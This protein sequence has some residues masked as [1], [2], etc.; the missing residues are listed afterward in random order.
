MQ[1]SKPKRG[2]PRGRNRQSRRPKQF[3]RPR[4]EERP[5]NEVR[6]LQVNR[7]CYFYGEQICFNCKRQNHVQSADLM[8]CTMERSEINTRRAYCLFRAR[9][10]RD[11]LFVFC[12]NC[13]DYLRSKSLIKIAGHDWFYIWPI[14]IWKLL[15][16]DEGRYVDEVWSVI[17]MNW[18]G[19]WVRMVEANLMRRPGQISMTHPAAIFRDVTDVYN[20]RKRVMKEL[21]IGD[22]LSKW[23]STIPD[24]LCPW[25]CTEYIEDTGGV[26]FDVLIQRCFP[27][28]VFPL[29]QANVAASRIEACESSRHDF[30]W[31]GSF[32]F[33]GN[34]QWVIQ[35]CVA[36]LPRVGLR[37][38][39]CRNCSGGHHKRFLHTPRLPQIL[40]A[41][42]GNQLA[43]A[44]LQP[45]NVRVIRAG[46]WNVSHQM[47][48]Q[49]SGYSGCDTCYVGNH[50]RF[51]SRSLIGSISE[52]L[53]ITGRQDVR[54]LLDRLCE[55][56]VLDPDT[57][58]LYKMHAEKMF[59]K[60][61]DFDSMRYG[62]TYV[63][64]ADCIHL[65]ACIDDVKTIPIVFENDETGTIRCKWPRRIVFVHEHTVYGAWFPRLP[66]KLLGDQFSAEKTLH[67]DL[68]VFIVVLL[69]S[70]PKLWEFLSGATKRYDDWSGKLLNFV[71]TQVFSRLV[72]QQGRSTRSVHPDPFTDACKWGHLDALT[73]LYDLL[74]WDYLAHESDVVPFLPEL[75]FQLIALLDVFLCERYARNCVIDL[76][77]FT[78]GLDVDQCDASAEYIVVMNLE[79]GT[80]VTVDA[81]DETIIVNGKEFEMRCIFTARSAG[82]GGKPV[83]YVRHGNQ[84][85]SWW[86]HRLGRIY[87][88]RDDQFR[89]S[90]LFSCVVYAGELPLD[91]KQ[92]RLQLL[93]ALG[94]QTNMSCTLHG[95]PM[96]VQQNTDYF[97]A[98]S[99]MTPVACVSSDCGHHALYICPQQ[100]CTA[101]MCSNCMKQHNASGLDKIEVDPLVATS[102]VVSRMVSSDGED[103]DRSSCSMFSAENASDIE[104]EDLHIGQQLVPVLCD[105][106]SV[107]DDSGDRCIYIPGTLVGD[108]DNPLNIQMESKMAEVGVR[109][110]LNHA[111]SMLV[112][113]N[114]ELVPSRREQQF[115][116]K[117][118]VGSPGETVP[119]VTLDPMLFPDVC[120]FDNKFDGS[121]IGG[122]PTAFFGGSEVCRKYN[123]ASIHDHARVRVTFPFSTSSTQ[124]RSMYFF[125][126]GISNEKLSTTDTRIIKDRGIF[127]TSMKGGMKSTRQ[128]DRV[129]TE[130]M[131]CHQQV[132]CLCASQKYHTDNLFL[133]FTANQSMTP[134]LKW[135]MDWLRSNDI[136][137]NY[138]YYDP[139][140]RQEIVLAFADAFAPL[141]NRN[142][143]KVMRDLLQYIV[144][145]EEKPVGEVESFF[146]RKEWQ[147]EEGNIDHWHILLQILFDASNTEQLRKFQSM[148]RGTVI[149]VLTPDEVLDFER[150]GVFKTKSDWMGV[151]GLAGTILTHR[152]GQ[153]KRHQRRIGTGDQDLKD[154]V[155]D[156]FDIRQSQTE[157]VTLPIPVPHTKEAWE[158]LCT[159]RLARPAADD[160]MNDYE[161]TH[162]L[163]VTE[164]HYAPRRLADGYMSP[165]HPLFFSALRSMQNIQHVSGHSKNAYVCGYVANMDEN[166]RVYLNAKSADVRSVAVTTEFLYNE[167]LSS[168]KH[169][170]RQRAEKAGRR[171]HTTGRAITRHQI[172][173]HIL[174]L[175]EV[176][177]NR[178]SIV[179]P[180]TA[181]ESR[182]GVERSA[183][184]AS[185]DNQEAQEYIHWY[186][187]QPGRDL[188]S[189][190]LYPDAERL[191]LN[192]DP[193]RQFSHHQVLTAE[194]DIHSHVTTD[195]ITTFSI[196]PPELSFV[197][198]VQ[199]YFRFFVLSKDKMSPSRYRQGLEQM[200]WMDGAGRR[201]LLRDKAL[202]EIRQYIQAKMTAK[203]P[204]HP[205]MLTLLTKLYDYQQQ[206][207]SY[208]VMTE[209]QTAEWTLLRK[210]YISPCGI[211]LLPIPVVT[212]IKPMDSIQ[213]AYHIVLSLGSYL[214]ELDLLSQRSLRDAY[215]DASLYSAQHPEQSIRTLL[216]RYVT[217]QLGYQPIGTQLFDVYLTAA[218]RTFR[219][220]LI[221][222][223]LPVHSLP[224]CLATQCYAD[225]AD[226]IRQRLDAF[227][228]QVLTVC[229]DRLADMLRELLGYLPTPEDV[230][231]GKIT[232]RLRGSMP[233]GRYQSLRS[234]HEQ[235]ELRVLI[236][237]LVHDYM[238]PNRETQA[239]KLIIVGAP[240]TGKTYCEFYAV[241]YMYA[242]GLFG[243]PTSHQAETASAAGGI[244]DAKA[245]HTPV[246]ANKTQQNPYHDAEKAIMALARDPFATQLQLEMDCEIKEE[247]EML[248]AATWAAEDIIQR[249]ICD[250]KDY[251]A[252]K[253]LV[254][255]MDHRQIKPC[256][257]ESF[258]LSPVVLS[259]CTIFRLRYF[260]RS[261][262]D[263]AL[264]RF[265]EILRIPKH[266]LR[267]QREE[268]LH[269]FR[270]IYYDNAIVVPDWSDERI[271]DTT[272]R[273]VPKRVPVRELERAYINEM[274]SKLDPHQYH[275]VYS[276]D[277]QK[278][279]Y[280][281]GNW[282][283][284]CRS[285]SGFLDHAVKEPRVLTLYE[286]GLYQ[287]T[288]NDTTRERKFNQSRLAVL[289]DLPPENHDFRSFAEI[290]VWMAPAA[291]KTPPSM[292]DR[293]HERL[294]HLGW[295]P[296]KIGRCRAYTQTDH[297]NG[298][299]A[300]RVQYGLRHFIATTIHAVIGATLDKA[301]IKVSRSDPDYSIWD[302]GMLQVAVTR[303][304]T[305]KDLIWVGDK[306]DTLCMLVDILLQE[307]RETEYVDSLIDRLSVNRLD[308][309]EFANTGVGNPYVHAVA[310]RSNLRR[311]QQQRIPN[312]NT[313]FSYIIIS[314]R[315]QAN[316]YIGEAVNLTVR[317]RKHNGG[318]ASKQ[319][320]DFAYRPWALLAYVAGFQGDITAHKTFEKRWQYYARR[321]RR[322]GDRSIHSAVTAAHYAIAEYPT[323]PLRL[324]NYA[325]SATTYE[326]IL[327]TEDVEV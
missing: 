152:G 45:R 163:L 192:L 143:D 300:K 78:G 129:F 98:N 8:F 132:N 249:T 168:S 99:H 161:I 53:S 174:G 323:F 205:T 169:F 222:E 287:I 223:S 120:P 243:V 74:G 187:L 239:G 154:R 22:L 211:A 284:A 177:T 4:R 193:W 212:S 147:G 18:R 111:G 232:D 127:A 272:I 92:L 296:V 133:T 67:T 141:F 242:C 14:Y 301:A 62:G 259:V 245:Y 6:V 2:R 274:K 39:T 110:I 3:Q 183:P 149:E 40:P 203:F 268:L 128:A 107:S 306:D 165:V 66:W 59:G 197:S 225:C 28:C 230:M 142:W 79:V 121:V 86:V 60:P 257:G 135:I 13:A 170:N 82:I 202:P 25:G 275:V 36:I 113:H 151:T 96:I 20:S 254:T 297:Q 148:I 166:V 258:L 167:K 293:T 228:H 217:E 156:A 94:G 72:S 106:D 322:N 29:D 41:S 31:Q 103:S 262:R 175:T 68:L 310:P 61:C 15:S 89:S 123:M 100:D 244:H 281:K 5:A 269:E 194:G 117:I 277:Q 318:T 324:I 10:V 294:H 116:Q 260:V 49:E 304:R 137:E 292:E 80:E 188:I 303:T 221:D 102:R 207:W 46:R 184:I 312:D 76:H 73:F 266:R 201:L 138:P 65:Q 17:P 224:S 226:D 71:T 9:D 267:A 34:P 302:A 286:K 145:S 69:S 255:T 47:V 136:L 159:L 209:A 216:R 24:V 134:G 326:D 196:R 105:D 172:M 231:H 241:L 139:T 108:T 93:E 77:E 146:G 124:A 198:H 315:T 278:P 214:T 200:L 316:L 44:V 276:T 158:I 263:P 261:S 26:W 252:D 237:R 234:Y 180:T 88:V 285:A 273:M 162:P 52:A 270:Q 101:G 236:R 157:H 43:H 97:A 130:C 75:A 95:L 321:A 307:N 164:R 42:H 140:F 11:G 247:G 104:M 176:S 37:V 186:H 115:L 283:P 290:E 56:N 219:S 91:Y 83:A 90:V 155:R 264:Q 314:I 109:S 144:Y 325:E 64:Y 309:H 289:L 63:S 191:A 21:K 178:D 185:S 279:I 256:E 122:I 238:D 204:I 114:R 295:K 233:R 313:G 248:S 282:Q 54:N 70:F 112:R 55:D 30:L 253:M 179:I 215:I 189:V 229:I 218:S 23:E 317:M 19:W 319:T 308:T 181:Y 208:Y 327:P 265:I 271:D 182:T 220:L 35:P 131:D 33:H 298:Y 12:R 81:L 50:G 288:F 48:T 305:F 32:S 206:E 199:E 16:T 153:Q 299:L 84:F 291:E 311:L 125:Y 1:S 38:L 118:V 150:R 240:G 57:V 173:G 227:K 280:S 250:S 251:K 160:S 58:A 126:D 235:E 320:K 27:W 195:R 210:R 7:R 87:Q 51:D 190:V 213:F 171:R 85:P 119:L 246:H